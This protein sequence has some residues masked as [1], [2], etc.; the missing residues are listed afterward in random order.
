MNTAMQ[1][2]IERDIVIQAPRERVYHALTDTEQLK[3]WFPDNIEGRFA[4]GEAPIFDFGKYGKGGV[5][6]VAAD[7]VEYVAYRWTPGLPRV[8]GY[9]SDPRK[10]P[11]TL[12]EFKLEEVPEGTRVIFRESGFASLPAEMYA[13]ALRDNTSGWDEMLV[14]LAK[15]V[16]K[17]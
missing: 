8:E 2:A 16:T 12:V 9:V 4:V 3:L 7:P 1:D 15:F 17:E 6:V 10:D 14:I 11:T 5:L 13:D